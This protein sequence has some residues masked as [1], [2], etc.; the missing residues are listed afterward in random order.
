M[1]AESRIERMSKH[2]SRF[3]YV[4]NTEARDRVQSL[5]FHLLQSDEFQHIYIFINDDK[6]DIT[7]ADVS[8]LTS[9]SLTL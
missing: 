1:K 4:F 8:Y 9:D 3:I 5:G 6:L 7:K 2:M